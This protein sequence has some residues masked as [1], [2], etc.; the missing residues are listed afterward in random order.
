MAVDVVVEVGL[1]EGS[2]YG[3]AMKL[4]EK[5]AYAT[6][7]RAVA[8]GVQY[9]P[10]IADATFETLNTRDA[11]RAVGV[12]A[13]VLLREGYTVMPRGSKLLATGDVSG[14]DVFP[15]EPGIALLAIVAPV[16]TP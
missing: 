14:G 8:G 2:E 3:D 6:D 15:P 1:V 5:L 9:A 12:L 13:S 16:G 4:R 11:L 10:L 7:A